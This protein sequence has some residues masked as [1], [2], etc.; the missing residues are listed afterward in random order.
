LLDLSRIE[1]GALTPDKEWYDLAELIAD[2][3][4]RLANLTDHHRLVTE[5]DPNLPLVRFDYVEIAQVLT[6][7]VENAVKY[8]PPGTTI[9]I[10][11]CEVPGAVDIAVCDTG[12]GIPPERLPRIFD[13]FYR[14]DP[15]ARVRGSGIG[16]TISKG[17]VEAH[18]GRI[19]V[20][21]REHQ[22][23]RFRFC[24]PLTVNEG[25]AGRP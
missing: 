11:A 23:T 7:L 20:E 5:I 15:A 16:L 13:K 19:V 9:T 3:E 25:G 18:G 2:V 21:S 1:G 12:P 24:L 8:T 10:S 14:A 22:G 6:N 17:L 4:H